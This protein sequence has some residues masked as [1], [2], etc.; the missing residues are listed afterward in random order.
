VKRIVETFKKQSGQLT[1]EDRA[2]Y[3]PMA[4]G[5]LDQD[6]RVAIVAYLLKAHFQ[7]AAAKSVLDEAA[8]DR[9]EGVAGD[10]PYAPRPAAQR[11]SHSA[12]AAPRHAAPGGTS[13][14]S[15]Q[16][17]TGG[18]EAGQPA[19]R[20]R[21]RRRGGG[22][23]GGG[24]GGSGGGRGGGQGGGQG[25]GGNRSGERRPRGAGDHYT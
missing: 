9:D 21:R 22:G 15:Q 20:R 1:A 2:E 11:Q 18:G 3:D 14:G 13:S 19:R 7:A 23:G 25:S 6:D 17:A 10:E 8:L 12:P 5:I 16:A 24:S 4:Q